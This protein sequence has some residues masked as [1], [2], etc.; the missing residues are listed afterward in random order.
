MSPDL[1]T[2]LALLPFPT[3]PL[4][5]NISNCLQ[6]LW[7]CDRL[8]SLHKDSESIIDLYK[9]PQ[10][11]N[12]TYREKKKDLLLN[13]ISDLFHTCTKSSQVFFHWLQM[14]HIAMTVKEE[15]MTREMMM[16]KSCRSWG[17]SVPSPMLVIMSWWFS[18]VSCCHCRLTVVV[19][20]TRE[21]H[22]TLYM[23]LRICSLSF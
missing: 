9:S 18:Q 4:P 11:L 3:P 8:T 23:P 6:R 10:T 17:K 13:L 2:M 12:L 21:G 14:A 20:D 16:W 15:K 19:A 22:Q 1:I 5:W 7:I